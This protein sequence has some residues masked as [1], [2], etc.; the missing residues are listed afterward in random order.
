MAFGRSSV[1]D[2]VDDFLTSTPTPRNIIDF[3]L[4]ESAQER[5]RR[6]IQLSQ[7]GRLNPDERIELYEHMAVET[8]LKRLKLKAAA[9]NNAAP[10]SK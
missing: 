1:W 9:K 10:P 8:F 4:S 6:L 2:E 7:D 3:Q 5:Y